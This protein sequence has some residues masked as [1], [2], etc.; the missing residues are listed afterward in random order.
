MT[1]PITTHVLDTARGRPAA[2]VPVV[3]Q[4]EIDGE[5]Q[6][7]GAATT[8]SDG[9]AT[10]LLPPDHQLEP[11]LYRL[12]F[13]TAAYWED[14]NR[15]G[16]FPEVTITFE[17]TVPTDHYHVPLLLSPFGYSTYRGS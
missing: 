13:D 5:W 7:L 17:L 15:V 10:T 11:G 6:N 4:A 16:F 14:T 8:S 12:L 1:S 3:L 9:R 2:G